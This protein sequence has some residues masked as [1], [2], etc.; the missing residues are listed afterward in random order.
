MKK[1]YLAAGTVGLTL[2]A[3]ACSGG[4]GQPAPFESNAATLSEKLE[5]A[6]GVKWHVSAES[7][8]IRALAPEQPVRLG[9]G[10]PAE[11]AAAFF[12]EYGADL[13][14]GASEANVIDRSVEADG[15]EYLRVQQKL[16]GSNV[17]LFDATSTL[18][19]DSTG[20]VEVILPGFI[21]D[22]SGVSTEPSIS[23]ATA[24]SRARAEWLKTCEFAPSEVQTSQPVLGAVVDGTS[25]RLAYRVAVGSPDSDCAADRYDIDAKTGFII[26]TRG[27]QGVQDTA[28]G[29]R[30]SLG[31]DTNDKKSIEVSE[32]LGVRSMISAAPS[33]RCSSYGTFGLPISTTTPGS[34]DDGGGAAVDA[35]FHTVEALRFF[36]EGLKRNGIDGA[37]LGVNVVVHDNSA[38]NSYGLNACFRGERP[39]VFT[40]VLLP[41]AQLAPPS[42]HIGDGRANL[43]P[44]STAYDIIAHELGHGIIGYSSKLVYEGE[45]G[46]LDESFA[47]VIGVSAREWSRL[48][49]QPS[50]FLIGEKMMR[51]GKGGFRD[52]DNPTVYQD[53]DHLSVALRCKAGEAPDAKKNDHC[54]VHSN[55][56][57]GNKAFALMVKGGTHYGY[58]I[59]KAIGWEAS[60]TIWYRAMTHLGSRASFLQAAE[61]QVAEARHFGT[62]GFLATACAWIAVGVLPASRLG[63]GKGICQE[64][65]ELGK[66]APTGGCSGIDDG[67]ACN[68]SAPYSAYVCKKGSIAGGLN[69]ADTSKVCRRQSKSDPRASVDPNGR[70]ICD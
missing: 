7:E 62:T 5:A 41:G 67:Y 61:A 50:S 11:Q 53:P 68:E 17:P 37:G 47:D 3:A 63:D 18:S 32:V 52:M 26:S 22:T 55:S 56:G 46:A 38:R 4:E 44:F 39:S 24:D 35:Y 28:G 36:K 58:G 70:L 43:L 45:S 34:W 42:V 51:V 8:G 66:S 64:T 15:V 20:R 9:I 16:P 65:L 31:L 2:L 49:G 54:Y 12:R 33:V 40:S 14:L 27:T 19:F 48:P 23:P 59:P 69:C 1:A 25:V 21:G 60:R 57:I 13:H 30:F 6:T 10:A 29:V